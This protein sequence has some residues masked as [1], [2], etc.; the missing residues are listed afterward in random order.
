MDTQTKQRV[1]ILKLSRLLGLYIIGLQG[2]GKSG[3]FEELIVQDIKQGI[4]VCVLDPHGELVDNIIARIPDKEKEEKVISLDLAESEYFFGLNL[5]ACSDPTNERKIA[6]A[7]SQVLHVFEKTFGITPATPLMYNVLHKTASA[8]IVNPGYTMADI[9]LFLT[10]EACRT[11]LIQKARPD[12][13]GFWERWD[14]PKLK[15]AKDREADSLTILNK[16]ND[17]EDEPLRYIIGQSQST[18][19]LRKIM[20]E[21]NIL[22]VKLDRQLERATSLIGSILVAQILNAAQNR[23]TNKLFNLYA[24]EFQNFATEDFA[25]LLEEAR[26]RGIG[27]TMAHQNRAQLELSD[28]QANKNL[29]ARTLNVGNLIVFRVPTDAEEL[30][31]QFKAN[32]QPPDII[33][34]EPV[35]VRATSGVF[36][37]LLKGHP[38]K[39]VMRFMETYILPYLSEWQDQKPR[40]PR[41]DLARVLNKVN[42]G[43]NPAIVL[44]N[45]IDALKAAEKSFDRVWE[46]KNSY[47]L[48]DI[49]YLDLFYPLPRTP[50]ISI[51]HAS[52]IKYSFTTVD[53]PSSVI[54]LLPPGEVITFSQRNTN[55]MKVLLFLVCS[56]NGRMNP[57][58]VDDNVIEEIRARFERELKTDTNWKGMPYGE[59]EPYESW[60]PRREHAWR[61]AVNEI[62]R[63]PDKEQI[64]SKIWEFFRPLETLLIC[65]R[66][67]LDG[68][69]QEPVMVNSGRFIPKY[70][71][72]E[73]IANAQARVANE[74]GRLPKFTARVR[75]SDGSGNVVEHTIQ[76]Y[77]PG[78]GLYGQALK[79]RQARIRQR[80]IRDGYLKDRA[81][82]EA[83]IR[84]RQGGFGGCSAPAHSEQFN[85][86]P[87]PLKAQ[88]RAPICPKCGASNQQGSLFCN[89]CGKKL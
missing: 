73:T 53:W 40:R 41:E 12:I 37:Q 19:D 56:K 35:M 60:F 84:Q 50:P 57:S 1:D 11:K 79:E 29:R 46:D 47:R 76:T 71:T 68:L 64:R 86:A 70:G 3:L 25:V 66:P 33:G 6:E 13:K 14:D 55:F 59:K 54:Q 81:T 80:N 65:L 45:P 31:K 20:D 38:N 48:F 27:V 36:E 32:P 72:E 75:L 4:G 77:A 52:W 58:W 8:L 44:L 30:A 63:H 26:K 39:A 42:T 88:R 5:F 69:I 24:D 9:S 89:Q 62:E 83:E 78:K 22:L 2:M 15:S 18:I 28:A 23:R 67:A 87:Q 74:L 7:R 17:F 16:L 85:P 10:D 21:G 51:E 49:A 61:K 34:Q 82:V 43:E